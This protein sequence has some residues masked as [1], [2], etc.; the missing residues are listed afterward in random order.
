MIKHLKLILCCSCFIWSCN[1]AVLDGKTSQENEKGNYAKPA[2]SWVKTRVK[3]AEERLNK[4]PAG[5][6][7]W[8][9]IQAHGGLEKWYNNGPIFFRFN[10]RPLDSTKTVRDTYQ[11]IDTW[12]ARAKHYLPENPEVLY[13]WD[14]ADAWKSTGDYNLKMN[15]RFW[16]I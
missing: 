12:S 14:G 1:S 4:T 10:Y 3:G 15:P 7:V 8:E 6:L 16:S 11:T 2:A 5:K 13:G 9:S